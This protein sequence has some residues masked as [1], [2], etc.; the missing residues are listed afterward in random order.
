MDLNHRKTFDSEDSIL[1][2]LMLLG[3]LLALC[4]LF[5]LI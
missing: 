4:V 2:V 1:S 3:I 5:P